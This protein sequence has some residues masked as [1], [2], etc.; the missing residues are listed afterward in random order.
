MQLLQA[1]RPGFL[2]W[3]QYLEVTGSLNGWGGMLVP[4]LAQR[5]AVGLLVVRKG[6]SLTSMLVLPSRDGLGLGI[7]DVSSASCWA[8]GPSL[9]ISW[10][11]ELRD[12][13]GQFT[14]HT[15]A[16]GQVGPWSDKAGALILGV[17]RPRGAWKMTVTMR[18]CQPLRGSALPGEAWDLPPMAGLVPSWWILSTG[19]AR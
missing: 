6:A 7:R 16:S 3:A 1:P 2:F 12:H 19:S 17:H 8:A 11:H 13:T 10:L 4:G 9:S 5:V 15:L 18:C 14:I